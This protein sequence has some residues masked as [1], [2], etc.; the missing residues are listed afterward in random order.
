MQ[1]TGNQPSQS[2]FPGSEAG[3]VVY[4]SPGAYSVDETGGGPAG[5]AK[6]I[7]AGCSGT[8]ANGDS[9]SCTITNDDIPA[10]LTVIKKVTNEHGGTAAPGDFTMS[11]TGVTAVGGNSFPAR[12][13]VSRRR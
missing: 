11:I 1:V 7:G 8:I 2:S 6:S 13:P 12:R 10:K 5:Y 9:K 3:T 4:L